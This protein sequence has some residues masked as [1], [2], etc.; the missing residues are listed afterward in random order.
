[1]FNN[2]KYS[3]WY[4]NIIENA[5]NRKEIFEYEKHHIVPRS[6]GGC[7]SDYNLVKLSFREHFICHLLLT[8]MCLD[9]QDEVKMLWALHRLTFS[10][11]YYSSYQYE[12]ARKKHIF[13]MKNNHPSKK[14]TWRDSVSKAVFE[15]WKD[16]EERRAKTSIKMKERWR[17]DDGK[18]RELA[19]QNLPSPMIGKDNPVVKQIEFYGKYYY[20]WRELYEGTGVSKHLYNRYY[21]NG[22]DPRS[23]IGANGP[24]SKKKGESV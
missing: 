23:R 5:K 4:F 8:K 13:N 22:I 20:G 2:S 14:E 15:T 12:L 18:L 3:K 11:D 9:R 1:M 10:K 24:I 19:I 6:M 17:N 21:L 16:N 7:D